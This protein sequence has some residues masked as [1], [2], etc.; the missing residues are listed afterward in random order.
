VL[1][2]PRDPLLQADGAGLGDLIEQLGSERFY[3]K[4]IFKS[5]TYVLFSNAHTSYA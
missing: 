2:G 4:N 5:F 1:R 3:F